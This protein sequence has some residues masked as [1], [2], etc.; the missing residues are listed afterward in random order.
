MPGLTTEPLS[1]AIRREFSYKTETHWKGE[2]GDVD[3]G[4]MGRTDEWTLKPWKQKR[5]FREEDLGLR[6]RYLEINQ[7]EGASQRGWQGMA[8]ERQQTREWNETAA[9]REWLFK[10]PGCWIPPKDGEHRKDE[11]PIGFM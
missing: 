7:R 10:G 9:K 2:V 5:Y 6:H 1:E 3:L 11:Q 8:R 4:F